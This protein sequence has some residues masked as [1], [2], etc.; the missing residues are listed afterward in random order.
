MPKDK[1]PKAKKL[2]ADFSSRV[3]KAKSALDALQGL[4][5]DPG[6][7]T[8]DHKKLIKDFARKS[9]AIETAT[10]VKHALSVAES[11]KQ[12]GAALAKLPAATTAAGELSDK[13]RKSVQGYANKSRQV[14]LLSKV[15]SGDGH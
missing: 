11:V 1:V 13:D 9:R 8:A 6:E 4:P 3:R 7:L 15:K 2:P 5:D 10:G 12:A 14:Q